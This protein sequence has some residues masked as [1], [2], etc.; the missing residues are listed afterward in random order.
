MRVVQ[1]AQ[2]SRML[3]IE[4]RIELVHAL[5]CR[6]AARPR[7]SGCRRTP[8]APGIRF[9]LL[10]ALQPVDHFLDAADRERRDDQLAAAR[11]AAV[12][13]RRQPLAVVVGLVQPIAVGRFDEQDVGARATG[14]GIGKHR[15]A[16]AAEVAAEQQRPA[17]RCGSARTPS[18]ADGRR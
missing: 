3:L 15:P 13:D 16:V 6:T 18:R 12:D 14:D 1:N 7:P 11:D 5:L 8:A 4:L 10:E 2:T 17:R 9:S